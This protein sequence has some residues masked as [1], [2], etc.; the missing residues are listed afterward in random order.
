MP[1]RGGGNTPSRPPRL[2]DPSPVGACTAVGASPPPTR[3]KLVGAPVP[4]A[5]PRSTAGDPSVG[6]PR[7]QLCRSRRDDR[8]EI[9]S[10]VA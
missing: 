10:T 6:S 8:C 9:S 1:V 4:A 2:Q 3:T 7:T 5:M